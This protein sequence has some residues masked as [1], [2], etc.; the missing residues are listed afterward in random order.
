[1]AEGGH[2]HPQGGR[3]EQPVGRRPA[4]G[5]AGQGTVLGQGREPFGQPLDQGG[6]LVGVEEP[7]VA[8]H[9]VHDPAGPLLAP[10]QQ[11]EETTEDPE[12]DDPDPG[13]HDDQDEG[14]LGLPAVVAG[15]GVEAV[16]DEEGHQRQPEHH[17]EDHGR[18]DALGAEGEAGIGAG[19]SGLGQQPVAE[20]RPRGRASR[21]HVAEGQGRH[22]DAEQPEAARAAVGQH[23][24]GELGI[25]SQGPD[26]QQHAQGQ[27]GDVDVG[28]GV[29][30]GPVAGQEGQGHI[31]QE[32]EDDEG[33]DADP[34][35][36]PDERSPVPPTLTRNGH[37]VCRLGH[38]HLH[39]GTTRT[40]GSDM[41]A[42]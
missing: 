31:E 39:V 22:V 40:T 14:R 32:Q 42:E 25:G 19:H 26:L 15:W 8:G 33:A 5:S 41:L 34:D 3:V 21:R 12:Q 10:G 6:G 24:V 18:A 11:I 23:G 20:G 9:P 29:D 35:L 16:G 27:V 38:H 1:V 13:G 4:H 37:L 7:D 2:E 36:A 28:Q 30:L 17:V